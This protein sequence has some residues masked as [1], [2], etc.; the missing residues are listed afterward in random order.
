MY[1]V[2]KIIRTLSYLKWFYRCELNVDIKGEVLVNFSFE[3][4]NTGKIAE[5]KWLW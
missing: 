5:K 2:N 4:Y 1:Q 3:I